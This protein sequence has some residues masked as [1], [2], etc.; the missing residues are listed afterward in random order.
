MKTYAGICFGIWGGLLVLI[1]AADAQLLTWQ[2]SRAAAV[3]AALSQD[4][5]I[6][7]VAGRPTCGNTVYMKNIVCEAT[8]PNIRGLIDDSYVPWFCNIDEN[9]EYYQY[10]GGLGGFTLP[11]ICCISPIDPNNYL[12]RTTSV[13]FV[14]EFYSRLQAAVP[15]PATPLLC[16][17]KLDSDDRTDLVYVAANGAAYY[18]TN[19]S[20]WTQIGDRK[21]ASVLSGD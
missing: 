6:L 8:S 4:K 9:T 15:G 1:A 21:F 3:A 11:L 16:A 5:Q 7:L 14:S 10:V 20:S 17:V 2:T 13:Q 12:N 19:L 18:T